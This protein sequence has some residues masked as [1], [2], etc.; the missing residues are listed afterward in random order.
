MKNNKI[1]KLI[2]T[3]IYN[4]NIIDPKRGSCGPRIT[5]YLVNH[6]FFFINSFNN[7]RI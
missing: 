6:I 2:K 1:N 7:W 3:G 5:T 4:E